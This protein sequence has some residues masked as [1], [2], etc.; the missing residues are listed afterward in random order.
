MDFTY[1]RVYKVRHFVDLKGRKVRIG[2][3]AMASHSRQEGMWLLVLQELSPQDQ[4]AY[5]ARYKM[6][7]GSSIAQTGCTKQEITTY[8]PFEWDLLAAPT[9]DPLHCYYVNQ[10]KAG[11]DVR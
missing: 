2:T 3:V 8:V 9:D 6:V 10:L 4:K 5:G 1:W 7:D 11:V